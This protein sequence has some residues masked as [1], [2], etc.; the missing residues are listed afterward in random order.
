MNQDGIYVDENGDYQF[1]PNL[2]HRQQRAAKAGQSLILDLIIGAVVLNAASALVAALWIYVSY[3]LAAVVIIFGAFGLLAGMMSWRPRLSTLFLFFFVLSGYE[4]IVL[5]EYIVAALGG[6]VEN[7][8]VE[9]TPRF[10]EASLF[11]F[12]DGAP[13]L[14]KVGQS[15]V[16]SKAGDT[17]AGA[18]FSA[19]APYVA[20][21]WTPAQPVTVWAACHVTKAGATGT[22]SFSARECG[23]FGVSSRRAV[24]QP[25]SGFSRAIDNAVETH[26]LKAHSDA[27]IVLF[28]DDPGAYLY[29]KRKWVVWFPVA[30]N[31]LFV[32]VV[33]ITAF[34]ARQREKR[35][36][37]PRAP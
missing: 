13:Q 35:A 36:E 1:D 15:A 32:L 4:A 7:L 21:G 18:A 12:A 22:L 30:I 16:V 11:H 17:R 2:A 26:G 14:D 24:A 33:L 8:K 28:V 27:L 6:G 31:G 34:R 19:V 3:R 37:G 9:D 5:E 23:D 10:K 25:L 29:N 20:K